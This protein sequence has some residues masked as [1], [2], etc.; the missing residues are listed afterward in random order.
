M[1]TM[2]DVIGQS[3]IAPP[4]F[5]LG[6]LAPF[7]LLA[8]ILAAAGIYGVVSYMV[9]Q[10]TREIGIRM[11]MGAQPKSVLRSVLRHGFRLTLVSLVL[12]VAASIDLT[13]WMST[14]LF[15]VETID[16]WSMT[17]MAFVIAGVVALACYV[18]AR[19]ASK[20]DPIVA[21]R[22]Q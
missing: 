4:R 16:P 15:G 17:A 18:P 8:V 9:A 7:G 12:G 22:H 5:Y 6:L 11:A 1:R 21:L 14:L 13:R 10:K 19:R 3:E 2:D 20:V